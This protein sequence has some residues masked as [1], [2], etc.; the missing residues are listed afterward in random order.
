MLTFSPL[1]GLAAACLLLL[2]LPSVSFAQQHAEGNRLTLFLGKSAESQELQNFESDY[3]FE[4]ANENHF[5]S[6]DGIELILKDGI[7]Q[8]INLY[9]SSK[10]YGSFAGQLPHGLAFG[11]S[12]GNVKQ[13]LGKPTVA[14]SS[15]YAEFELNDCAISCG[16]EADHLS[17]VTLNKKG[18]E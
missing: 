14:Y 3:K 6:K 13:L 1:K 18:A 15:G 10:V 12:S 5:L 16:F 11:M 17:Q 2:L 7:L 4:M 8:Q 9:K